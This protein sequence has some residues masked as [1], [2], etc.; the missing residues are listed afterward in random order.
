MDIANY[1]LFRHKMN[2]E[3]VFF[4]LFKLSHKI[5]FKAHIKKNII[6]K[7]EYHQIKNPFIST[8]SI[9]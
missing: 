7:N 9:L 8:Q 3:Q 5:N 4:V 2:K 1:S 6:I